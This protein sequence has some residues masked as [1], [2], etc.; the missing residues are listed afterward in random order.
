MSG[1][2]GFC[3]ARDIDTVSEI[4]VLVRKTS[5]G[6]FPKVLTKAL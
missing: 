2:F 6:K 3:R 1:G 5:K 4:L